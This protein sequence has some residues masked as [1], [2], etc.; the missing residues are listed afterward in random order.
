MMPLLLDVKALDTE[1]KKKKKKKKK[2]RE[3]GGEKNVPSS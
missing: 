1:K 3:K 2:K